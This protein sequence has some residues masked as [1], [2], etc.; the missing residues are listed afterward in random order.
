MRNATDLPLKVLYIVYWG[1]AEPL[2][3][4]LVL[5][6]IKNLASKGMNLTLVTFEKPVDLANHSLIA[7]IRNSM[8]QSGVVWIALRYHQQPKV[9]FD[10][11]QG[12]WRALIIGLRLRPDVV[13]ARN[14]I[15]GLIGL[16]LA[17]LLRAK[18]VYHNEGFFPDEQV[19]GG[20]WV[21][22][23]TTHRV[24][25]FLERQMYAR[26]D[27]I[28]ALSHRA[29]GIIINIPQV[30]RK[31]TSVI[32]VPSCVD[33]QRFQ[34]VKQPA[35]VT[36]KELQLIYIGSA[37]RR[38][39]LDKIGRFVAVAKQE[40]ENIHLQVLTRMEKSLVASMLAGGGLTESHW[41]YDS[42]PH[43]EIPSYLTQRQAGLFF[44]SQ[45]LS[46]HGCSP[47]KIGEYWACGLPVVTTANVSDTDDIIRRERVGVVVEAHTDEAY[48]QA[49]HELLELLSNPELPQRCRRAAEKYY[50]LEPACERQIDLYQKLVTHPSRLT[51]AKTVPITSNE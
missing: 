11:L 27:G 45:G 42:V 23:S 16:L 50:A 31:N 51:A 30:I 41:S 26:A 15:A 6:A 49:F 7:E 43:S 22:N 10:V 33:L 37:G 32:V 29:K 17:P 3:Q 20:V 47:T 34:P 9:V 8:E 13:H 4:S 28:I 46:E 2:G 39:R 44:L 25:K 21:E 14:F 1:A 38:Y 48:R 12:L 24:F 35:A 40:M 36:E 5:P 19:D 18:L